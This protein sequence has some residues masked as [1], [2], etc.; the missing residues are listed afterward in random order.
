MW[1]E[2]NAREQKLF[3]LL[4]KI[5]PDLSSAELYMQTENLNCD[6]VTR[7]AIEY[8]DEC[9]RDAG[10]YAYERRIPHPTDIIPNLNSTYILDVLSLLLRY[11]LDPNAIHED[12][13]IMYSLIYIDN[14]FLAADALAMLLDHGGKP[15]LMLPGE[16]LFST[17]DFD[18]F[19]YATDRYIDNQAYAS[20]VHYWMV[21]IGYGARYENN[22]MQIFKELMSSKVFDLQKLRN[23]RNYYFGLTH[24][25][26]KIAISIYDKETFWEV[27]RIE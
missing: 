23:H 2:L 19:N 3:D 18:V 27:A 17:T 15:D 16:T 10:D 24:M 26:N 22:K 4:T 9:F 13:N 7:A 6:E 12:T 5:P 14:E 25:E 1:L 20:L 11:G 21:L 8:A